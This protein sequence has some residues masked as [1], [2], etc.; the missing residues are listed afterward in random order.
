MMKK[1]GNRCIALLLALL[2]T[3]MPDMTVRA[4]ENDSGTSEVTQDCGYE[5]PEAIDIGK[6]DDDEV[7]DLP[8]VRAQYDAAD[9]SYWNAYGSN[10]YYSKLTSEEKQFYQALYDVNMAFLTENKSAGYKTFDSTR[11]YHSGFVPIGNLDLDTALDIA[12]IVQLSNPQF[13]FV[14]EEMLY[15]VNSNGDFQL[16]LGVYNTCSNG[17]A[18]ANKT[19][20]IKTKLDSWV[21][22]KSATTSSTGGLL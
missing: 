3:V 7:E 14:N 6:I 15:G 13:Y 8:I 17:S 22:S 11:H 5:Q 2:L 21:A 1:V 20:E 10:Y 16:A 4:E 18:R 9:A 19:S 12:Q